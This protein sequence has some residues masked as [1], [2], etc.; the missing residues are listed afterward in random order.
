MRMFSLCSLALFCLFACGQS[1]E[2]YSSGTLVGVQKPTPPV[3]T[4]IKNGEAS[5][6]LSRKPTAPQALADPLQEQG[7]PETEVEETPSITF[8]PPEEVP[9]AGSTFES[10]DPLAT[11][12]NKWQAATGKQKFAKKIVIEKS[13][14]VITIYADE[15]P[16]IRYPVE[17]GFAPS[18]DK[19]IQGDG[20]TPEG[21]L[22]VC[23]KNSASKFHRFLGLSYPQPDDAERGL[24]EKRI[25]TK[26]RNQIINA[27]KTKAQPSWNT[28]L[29]GAVGIHGGGKFYDMGAALLGYDWTLGCIALTDEASE[30][31]FVF[32]EMGTPVT[33]YP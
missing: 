28:P 18:G 30:A 7:D 1:P 33:I 16:L 24:T 14:R 15:D 13:K 8:A 12:L 32:A 25:T 20:K 23:T 19:S 2:K 3:K 6:P 29:G 4:P 31:I 22:Y 9:L 17:L 10:K 21:E 26:Q 11:R 27:H 5:A